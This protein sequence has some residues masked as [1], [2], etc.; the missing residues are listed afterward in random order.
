MRL[1]CQAPSNRRT[2]GRTDR[3]QESNLVHLSLKMWHLV[4]IILT[5]FLIINWPNL[6]YLLVDGFYPPPLNFYKPRFVS[7]IGWTPLTDTTDKET[8]ERTNG[9]SVRPSVR[10]DGVW[11]CSQCSMQPRGWFSTCVAP[12]MSDALISLHWLRVP[13][14]IRS[15]VAVLVYKVIHDCTPSYL[16]LFTYVAHLPSR[17]GLRSSYSDCLVQPPINRSTVGSRAFSVAGP[18]CHRKL[19]GKHLWQL[20]A[21]YSRR[22]CSQSRI[23]AFD[24]CDIFV[25]TVAD[26]EIVKR[27]NAMY[28]PSHHLL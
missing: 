14:R 20:H 4:A 13:E 5:N 19:R 28:Q 10:P 15:K 11:H 16:D 18:V 2:H 26:P 6:V 8:N 23:L 24:S 25:Y 7:P 3:L 12:T 17:R 1:L 21:L 9:Q 22:F 27:G